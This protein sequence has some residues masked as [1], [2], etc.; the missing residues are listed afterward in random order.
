[1]LFQCVNMK[2]WK[3]IDMKLIFINQS[4]II[5]TTPQR[6]KQVILSFQIE[7][8]QQWSIH[9]KATKTQV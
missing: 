5:Y 8:N 2:T 4:H 3:F 6:K 1:M 9:W 7:Y